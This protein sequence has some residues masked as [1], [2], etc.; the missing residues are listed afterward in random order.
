MLHVAMQEI[1][2]WVCVGGRDQV[3]FQYTMGEVNISGIYTK[4][5][6]F[7]QYQT[8]WLQLNC[9]CIY[10]LTTFLWERKGDNSRS[11]LNVYK[12]LFNWLVIK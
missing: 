1:S 7:G 5:L 8:S 2:S 4:S 3:N 6:S 11:K 12:S 10:Y 9:K